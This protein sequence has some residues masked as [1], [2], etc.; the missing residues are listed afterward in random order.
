MA[1]STEVIR[2]NDCN[3]ADSSPTKQGPAGCSCAK[4]DAALL[5]A[6]YQLQVTGRYA[7]S[8]HYLRQLAIELGWKVLLM[9]ESI[10]R[11]NAGQPIWGNLCVLQHSTH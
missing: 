2:C 7:H 6:N 11:Y 10:I 5:A 3:M 4:P 8:A 1:F 9:R